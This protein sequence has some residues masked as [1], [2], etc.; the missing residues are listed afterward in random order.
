MS[1]ET[2]DIRADIR[3]VL[4]EYGPLTIPQMTDIIY[5][6][7]PKYFRQERQAKLRHHLYHMERVGEVRR[8]GTGHGIP[9]LWCLT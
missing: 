8:E 2:L 7:K 1:L 4:K 5:H 9:W 3:H 6:D